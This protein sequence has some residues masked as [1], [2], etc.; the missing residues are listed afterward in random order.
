MAAQALEIPYEWLYPFGEHGGRVYKKPGVG[1]EYYEF[2]H[3]S[4]TQPG[5]FHLHFPIQNEDTQEFGTTTPTVAQ[6]RTDAAIIKYRKVIDWKYRQA[7]GSTSGISFML[8]ECMYLEGVTGIIVSATDKTAEEMLHRINNA[9]R[10]L[11]DDIKV[12]LASSRDTGSKKE[13][14]FEHGGRILVVSAEGK[15]PGISFSPSRVMI[16]EAGEMPEAT[17][18]EL[19]RLLGPSVSKKKGAA[20]FIVSTT[21]RHGGFYYVHCMTSLSGESEFF[22]LFL[23]WWEDP[24]CYHEPDPRLAETLTERERRLISL[25]C[26]LGNIAFRR[27]TTKTWMNGEEEKFDWAYPISPTEGWRT[28]GNPSL[29]A[30]IF[31]DLREKTLRDADVVVGE[32][33][34]HQLEEPVAGADYL[35]VIDPKGFGVKHQW[36]MSVFKH[37]EKKNAAVGYPHIREVAWR[38]G[39]TNPLEQ[40]AAAIAACDYYA[41][42]GARCKLVVES[43]HEAVIALITAYRRENLCK[44]ELFFPA[45]QNKPGWIS[46]RGKKKEAVSDYVRAVKQ[47][48]L[49]VKQ[50][51]AVMQ[52]LAWDSE[53]AWATGSDA[54]GESHHFDTLIT[55]FIA[56]HVAR[57]LG[58]LLDVPGTEEDAGEKKTPEEPKWLPTE[59]GGYSVSEEVFTEMLNRNRVRDRVQQW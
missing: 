30:D 23:K 58:W 13:I 8:R 15:V 5:F 46:S 24:N 33:G 29:P 43:N 7:Y 38:R 19:F 48:S 10:A 49:V 59:N 56:A 27:N 55:H 51:E 2:V 44:W 53:R 14:A 9:Y 36:A 16:D 50:R 18:T 41:S 37:D 22:P 4:L 11:P 57:R 17:I 39:K 6:L 34:C 52:A 40:A 21:G 54:A 42:L 45:S 20:V 1:R 47:K 28:T 26:S 12:G 31:E 3:K 35:F 32:S 25:G